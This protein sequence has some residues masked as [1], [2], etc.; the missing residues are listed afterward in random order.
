MAKISRPYPHT[1]V[2]YRYDRKSAEGSSLPSSLFCNAALM[3]DKSLWQLI[4]PQSLENRLAKIAG[5]GLLHIFDCVAKRRCHPYRALVAGR[6][7]KRRRVDL[8]QLPYPAEVLA[9][10]TE[11][12][13]P[14]VCRL[15]ACILSEDEA[16]SPVFLRKITADDA[17]RI[18]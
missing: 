12:H 14:F 10:D 8:R 4:L 15:S 3:L 13:M 5:F 16:D 17:V 11:Y 6:S 1:F 7:C 18:L 2:D 9:A